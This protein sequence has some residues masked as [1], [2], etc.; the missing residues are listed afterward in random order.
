MHRAA[1]SDLRGHRPSL[2]LVAECQ[3]QPGPF[4]EQV[5]ATGRDL[6]Q[7][8][9]CSLD[10]ERLMARKAAGRAS[11]LCVLGPVRVGLRPAMATVWTAP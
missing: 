7:L 11:E 9:D 4:G 10:V 2:V 8:C 3:D 1:S 6:P 5:A